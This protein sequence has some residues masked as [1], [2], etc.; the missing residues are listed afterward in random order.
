MTK[1]SYNHQC[2]IKDNQAWFPVMGEIHYSRYPKAYWKESIYKMK[3]G[4]IEVVSTYVIWI[5]HEE[6]EG[7]YD[8]SGSRD[9][10]GFLQICKECEVKLFLRI[11]PWVH[12]EVRNG[13]FP[14]W[15]LK[16]GFPIR[17]ND[18][19][20]LA[21]VE[22]FYSCI[23]QQVDGYLLKDGGPVIGVQIENEYGHVGGLQGEEG[24]EHMRT[25]LAL[26]KRIGFEVPI[27]TAT[28][29]GG[30]VTGGMLP[31]MGG[32]CD[33]PWDASL[34]ELPPNG[35]YVFTEERNDHNIGS[36]YKLGYG[37]TFDIKQFPYL[38]AELGGGLQVTHHRRPVASAKDIGAMTV[39]KLGSGVNLLGYYMYHGGTNPK[40]KLTTLQESKETGS[41]NDLPVMSYDFHAPIREYGQ[42]SETYKEIKLIAMFLRDFGSE[43]CKMP[44]TF[45]DKNPLFPTN[46]TDV[47]IAIRQNGTEGYVFINNYQRH[48]RM[49]EHKDYRI[50]VPLLNETIIFPPIL[51]GDK[52]FFFYPFN[53]KIGNARLK[54]A[55]ATPLCRLE[56]PKEVGYVFYTD[57]KPVYQIEGEIGNE[58]IITLSREDAKNAYKIVRKKQYLFLSESVIVDQT[59]RICMIGRKI[60]EFRV[61]PALPEVPEG[62]LQ[63]EDQEGFAV[64][65]KEMVV[66]EGEVFFTEIERTA[67]VSCYEIQIL[68]K[69]E[70]CKNQEIYLILEYRGDCAQLW[71]DGELED[72]HF[73]QGENWEI[74]LRRYGFPKKVQIR[75]TVLKES[76]RRFLEVWPEMEAGKGEVCRLD[77]VRQIKEFQTEIF[78]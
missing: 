53:M 70:I 35:N 42:V 39:V 20:Y 77:T 59:D 24:E 52:D 71:I 14:D 23:Y 1:Y 56:N 22:R 40:G 74:G 69:D 67:Q 18:I 64:Y 54:F 30:A 17:C 72:D 76:D 26:A 57:R 45:P 3:A 37:L 44:A 6:V 68:Y 49:E 7:E 28:G 19:H 61:Y 75:I 12:G 15:L 13:G 63:L 43:L 65:R 38:T 66:E 62:F 9:L 46:L 33:A 2:L 51:I 47:R 73:Y 10:R 48:Y 29:W 4:G 16:K 50:Q 36:D 21:E 25:L 55:L 31:V 8:F 34:E 11:G 41:P 58:K 32:Y 60:P 5:H 27:Y 78:L